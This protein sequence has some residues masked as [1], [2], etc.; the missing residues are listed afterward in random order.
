MTRQTGMRP[1]FSFL[2]ILVL[3]SIAIGFCLVHSIH[4]IHEDTRTNPVRMIAVS[5]VGSADLAI[6]NAARY[7]RHVSLTD[8]STPFQDCPGC[9]DYFPETMSA[10]PP[11]FLGF[12]TRFEGLK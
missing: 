2:Y 4:A 10:N 7:I 11:D 12:Q 3:L 8:V 5:V 1:S 9:L 6:S